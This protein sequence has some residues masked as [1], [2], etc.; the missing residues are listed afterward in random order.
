[1]SKDNYQIKDLTQQNVMLPLENPAWV[2]SSEE[3]K[4]HTQKYWE[5]VRDIHFSMTPYWIKKAKKENLNVKKDLETLEDFVNQ[6]ISICDKKDIIEKPFNYFIPEVLWNNNKE[7]IYIIRSSG[8]TGPKSHY[9]WWDGSIDYCANFFDYILNLHNVPTNL[10]WFVTGTYGLL[11]G[12]M[13]KLIKK[14]KGCIDYIPI[15]AKGIK[16]SLSEGDMEKL[17]SIPSL[18][19]MIE[20]SFNTL[21][22]GVDVFC[23][24]FPLLHLFENAQGFDKVKVIYLGIGIQHNDLQMLQKKYKDKKF[25]NTYGNSNTGVFPNISTEALIYY[26]PAPLSYMYVVDDNDTFKVVKYGERGRLRNLKM[27]QFFLWCELQDR[28][29]AERYLP[30]KEFKWDGIKEVSVDWRNK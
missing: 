26:P 18:S 6:E 15:E 20:E 23:T 5:W 19:V 12:I 11:P 2:C 30:N 24:I 14:R 29:Y 16:H 13:R 21:R 3:Y 22:R 1:M 7:E 27:D 8:T 9:F 17:T 4:E 10:S 28:D 25:F